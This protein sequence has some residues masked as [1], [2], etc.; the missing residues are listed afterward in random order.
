MPKV[1]L[2]ASDEIVHAGRNR[3]REDGAILLH[4]PDIRRNELDICVADKLSLREQA[5]KPLIVADGVD[6]PRNLTDNI[7]RDDD[8]YISEP[9]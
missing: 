5:L 7:L 8:R 2:V 3:R 4:Q 6:I 1:A 9:P